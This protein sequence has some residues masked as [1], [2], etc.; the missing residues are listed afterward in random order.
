MHR[1]TD[2]DVR[3]AAALYEAGNSLV[4]VGE[5]FDVNARTVRSAF[6]RAGV[7]VRPR[8]GWPTTSEQPR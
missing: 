1:L 8:R 7:A 6:D 5:H 4:T 2:D 3:K